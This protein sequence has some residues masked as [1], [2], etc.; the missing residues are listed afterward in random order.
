M[1]R[2]HHHHVAIVGAGPVGIEIAAAMK[3]EGIDYVHFDAGQIGQTIYQFTPQTRFF[4][5]NERIA[6]AGVP[7][8]T[9]DQSKS[10]R[11]QYLAYLRSVVQQ[12]DLQVRTYERLESIRRLDDGSF[13]LDTNGIRG[14]AQWHVQKL[15]LATGGTAGPRKLGIP[16]EDQENVHHRFDD[17]HVYFRTRVL[18]VGGKNSAIEAAL[19]CYHAG[20]NVSMSYRRAEF[21]PKHIKY[22]L[23]P[24]ITGLAKAGRIDIHY[25]TQMTSIDGTA[26]TLRD[27]VTGEEST[28]HT[29]FVLVLIG[30]RADMSLA[31]MAGVELKTEFEVPTINQETMETN[32]P[33]VYIAGTA[34]AGT[35]D[36]FRVFIEN[37]HVH[38]ERI[39]ASILGRN[40]ARGQQTEYL[41]PES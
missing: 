35:Q 18:I 8:Q 1:S 16:G 17:P 22:W 9:C 29:D 15:V 31:R 6:I 24:E 12:F 2:T 23:Y 14:P 19:R 3:R 34:I 27:V 33:G 36:Q 37:C 13:L 26:V 11:E 28:V 7:L 10:T 41:R 5:S 39:V 21:D 32:V 4:S 20:A 40:P 25:N 38:S 30:Y